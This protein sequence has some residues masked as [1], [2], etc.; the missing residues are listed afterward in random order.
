MLYRDPIHGSALGFIPPT[1]PPSSSL[2]FLGEAA[3]EEE[4]YLGGPFV[5]A[6]G[7][8]LNR[9]LNMSRIDRPSL[10]IGNVLSCKPPNNFLAGAPYEYEAVTTC[11][12]TH[13][14]GHLDQWLAQPA[15]NKV[16]VTLG[17]IPLRSI[18]TDLPPKG[19]KVQDFHGTVN[20]DP[21]DRFWVVPT[22][23]PS[24]LQRGAFNLMGVMSYDLQRAADVAANGFIPEEVALILDPEVAWFEAWA[25][26]YCAQVEKTPDETWLAVDVETPDKERQTDEG[27]LKLKEARSFHIIRINFSCNVDEG[28][29]VPFTGPYLPIIA[30][31]LATRG[32]KVFWNADYDVK[33]LIYRDMAINGLIFDAMW[34]WHVLQSDLPRGL[35][36]VSPLYSPRLPPWKHLSHS[37]PIW[38]AANDGVRTLR[39]GFG[40]A[41][42]LIETGMWDV[43]FFRHTVCLDNWA[44]S[45]AESVGLLIDQEELDRFIIEKQGHR[46]GFATQLQAI[47]PEELKPLTP[48]N[49]LVR[50]PEGEA[51]LIEKVV[52]VAVQKCET[53]RELQ[54][55]KKHRCRPERIKEFY[56]EHEE[57]PP[58]NVTL[59]EEDVLRYF[60]REPFNP[61]SPPQVMAYI[62]WR[63]HT[64]GK[65]KKSKKDSTNKD[66]LHRLAKKTKDPLYGRLLEIRALDKVLTTYAYGTK[67]K[68]AEDPRSQV[69]G[70]LHAVATHKPSTQRLSMQNPN[71]Q[72]VIADRGGKEALSAGFRRVIVA[73]AGSWL[74]EYDYSAIEAVDTGWFMGDPLYMRLAKLSIHAYVTSFLAGDP[75]D[76]KWSDVDLDR[77]LMAIKARY[78]ELY[79]QAKRFV[80]G[81]NY[82]MSVRGMVMQFPDVF[83]TENAARKVE[84]IYLSVAPKLAPWRNT[85]REFASKN[86]FLGGKIDYSSYNPTPAYH[87]YGYKH[88]YYN[89]LEY[90]AVK[91]IAPRGAQVVQIHGKNYTVQLGEDGKRC[92]AFFP[93]STAAG[94]IKEAM[95]ELFDRDH[96]NYIGE[97]FHGK[98]P[99]RAQIHDSLLLEVPGPRVEEVDEKVRMAMQRPI[100]EQP[101]PAEWGMGSHLTIG[102]AAKIGK[103][104]DKR[105]EK[106]NPDGM[107]K[108]GPVPV[109]MLPQD[110]VVPI[111]LYDEELE[112][113][114]DPEEI[115]AIV[116]G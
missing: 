4:F 38:Y 69:D 95:L 8:L 67:K 88:W 98:T 54:V 103:N 57:V 46:D 6:A 116:G 22:Y 68:L 90:R 107:G 66:S 80:H 72:N 5:G 77:H 16:L 53:C 31:V 109:T 112:D 52:R 12:R 42:G 105:D 101:C 74:L 79:E 41:A 20:R 99:L 30:R 104:W 106:S 21:T 55:S 64:P 7:A 70:R 94:I 61:A 27:E 114:L 85:V 75:A 14:Q 45:P 82:G 48:K 59:A 36:F 58:P 97:A 17:G 86:R 24:H 84:D 40:A 43:P 87:P 81:Y 47:Y 19:V 18:L 62:R 39:N 96:P 37:E 44:L 115:A 1:G 102:V 23:H 83:P 33:R 108:Y 34:Q 113:L 3:G 13:L 65:D 35:G 25:D 89:V 15:P 29:T 49:G 2:F 71:L 93:Q 78:P 26:A 110:P 76:P 32:V 50:K 100:E 111:D 92:V 73:E 11:R 10:R 28:I 56:L 51:G 63:G 9:V 60:R 91:G